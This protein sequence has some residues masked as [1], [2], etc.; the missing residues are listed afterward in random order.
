MKPNAI[1]FH[2]TGGNPN[3]AWYP[4]LAGRLTDRGYAV[5]IPHYPGINIEPVAAMLP[6]VLAGHHFGGRTVLVGHSGGA[7]LLLALLE[8]LDVAVAQA[9]LVAG[10]CTQPNDAAEPVLQESYDWSAIKA[11]ARELCFINSRTDP[12]GCDE[13]QGRAMFDRLGGTQIIRDDGHFGDYD[14]VYEEFPLL[15]RLVLQL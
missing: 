3:V 4:W 11:H 14:Q 1:I 13:H 12:Y 6:K 8:H 5:E 2:G 9:I 15:D 7:A 10:Y